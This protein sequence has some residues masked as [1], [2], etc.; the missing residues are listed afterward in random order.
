MDKY[1]FDEGDVFPT[2]GSLPSEYLRGGHITSKEETAQYI[3]FKGQN[4]NLARTVSIIL[5][6]T[7]IQANDKCSTQQLMKEWRKMVREGCIKAKSFN[8]KTVQINGDTYHVF[9][10]QSQKMGKFDDR[11]NVH[12]PWTTL[13]GFG[14]RGYMLLFPSEAN[15]DIVFE[16][17]GGVHEE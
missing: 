6:A 16:W 5:S 4:G 7:T 10:L 17:I 12:V 1:V 8:N 9:V 2:Q 15:R 14:V 3:R 11:A 13:H